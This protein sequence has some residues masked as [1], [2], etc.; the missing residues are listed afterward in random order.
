ME[1]TGASSLYG[2]SSFGTG[3]DGLYSYGADGGG[4]AAS[5]HVEGLRGTTTIG[6]TDYG[7][8]LN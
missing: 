2:S 1:S 4:Y 3:G 7:S 6:G 8:S 5:T